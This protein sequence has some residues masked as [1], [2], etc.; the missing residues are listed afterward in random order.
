MGEQAQTVGAAS[1]GTISVTQ[2]T[3]GQNDLRADRP[4]LA[5]AHQKLAVNVEAATAPQIVRTGDRT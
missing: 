4:E 5:H 2:V 3:G 1:R